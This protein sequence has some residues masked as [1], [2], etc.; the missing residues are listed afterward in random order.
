MKCLTKP[1]AP[2]WLLAASLL[3]FV[4]I[5]CKKTSEPSSNPKEKSTAQVAVKDQGHLKQ[6][7]TFSSDVIIQW[8]NQQ[9]NM[10]RVPLAPGTGSQAAER[11][12][13]YC[14]IAAYESVVEGMPSYQSLSG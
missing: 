12:L 10:L 8:L 11:A 5:S 4:F 14:G 13:A 6:T 2:K 1:I 9:L 7:K 3:L